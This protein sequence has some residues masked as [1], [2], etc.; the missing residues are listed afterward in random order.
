MPET[1]AD[2][3]RIAWNAAAMPRDEINPD[4]MIT[5]I[6]MVIGDLEGSLEDRGVAADWET[7]TIKVEIPAFDMGIVRAT[8]Q[9]L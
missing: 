9:T 3:S 4:T 1:L 8:V 5:M 2:P 6:G 7:L